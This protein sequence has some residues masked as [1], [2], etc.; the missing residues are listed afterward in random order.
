MGLSQL[1][2]CLCQFFHWSCTAMNTGET[3]RMD[4]FAALLAWDGSLRLGPQKR[5]NRGTTG[6]T[7]TPILQGLSWM[8][9]LFRFAGRQTFLPPVFSQPSPTH[10]IRLRVWM[11]KGFSYESV[12][13]AESISQCNVGFAAAFVP[14]FER[15]IEK[16]H[17]D[18]GSTWC[19][20][21]AF[22]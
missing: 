10:A 12:E 17:L 16:C 3:K 19:W 14:Q 9:N 6:Q 20:Y 18:A 8:K 7:V 11:G 1:M 13:G 15:V 2:P 21:G 5:R 22:F 4:V